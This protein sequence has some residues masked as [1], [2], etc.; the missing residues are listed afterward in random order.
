MDSVGALQPR[1]ALRRQHLLVTAITNINGSRRYSMHYVIWC[2]GWTSWMPAM[3][4]LISRG[5]QGISGARTLLSTISAIAFFRVLFPLGCR[6]LRWG[7]GRRWSPRLWRPCART[8]A[9]TR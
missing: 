1:V 2:R 5:Q 8:G 6:H 3:S 4:C 9:V 7:L